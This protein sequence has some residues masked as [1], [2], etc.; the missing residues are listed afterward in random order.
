MAEHEREAGVV[1]VKAM[2]FAAGEGRRMRPLTLATPKPLLRVG[3]QSLLQHLI[4]KLYAAGITELVVNAAYLADQVLKA[5][6]M[7]DLKGMP[8]YVSVEEQPLETGGGLKRA[9]PYLGEAPFLLVN[10]D[11]WC[12]FDLAALCKRTLQSDLLAHLVLVESPAHNR[13]GDFVLRQSGLL[14]HRM[15]QDG[16]SDCLTFSGIS[17]M[18]PEFVRRYSDE[19]EVFPLRDMLNRALEESSVTGELFAGYWSDV[20]TPER[21]EQVR[22][23]FEGHQRA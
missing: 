11:V 16:I 18:K 10:S 4:D 2:I 12:D 15:E 8:C 6:Q 14:R 20:G 1:I 19:R 22:K 3:Q 21:L 17:L 9:L 5:I 23:R 7:M 13:S